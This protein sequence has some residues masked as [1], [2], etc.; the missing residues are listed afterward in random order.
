MNTFTKQKAVLCRLWPSKISSNWQYV[1]EN[2]GD[3]CNADDNKVGV[4]DHK[5]DE[6]LNW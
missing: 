6:A 5:N 1:R 3:G 2:G 4:V